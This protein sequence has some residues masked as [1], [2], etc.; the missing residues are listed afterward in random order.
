M[1]KWIVP[2]VIGVV[3]FAFCALLLV[4]ARSW[5]KIRPRNRIVGLLLLLPHF[6]LLVCLAL[7]LR[8]NG[9]PQGSAR[10]NEG[11]GASI[12]AMFL[13]P[14]PALLGSIGSLLVFLLSRRANTTSSEPPTLRS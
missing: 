6:L 14:I 5:P 8:D 12:Y 1:A 2:A 7:A 9:A 13:L 3:V 10:W 11:F 4:A